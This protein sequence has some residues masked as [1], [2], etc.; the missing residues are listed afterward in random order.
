MPEVA[1]RTHVIRERRSAREISNFADKKRRC[2]L[3]GMNQER[4]QG[5]GERGVGGRAQRKE[6]C[7]RDRVRHRDRVEQLDIGK[8]GTREAGHGK[9]G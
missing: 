8:E 3:G 6:G 2:G 1:T 7:R 9:H 4:G 5:R